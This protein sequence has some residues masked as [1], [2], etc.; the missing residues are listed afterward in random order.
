MKLPPDWQRLPP[1]FPE[2][3]TCPAGLT[4]VE[5][6]MRERAQPTK[7][8]FMVEPVYGEMKVTPWWH[9]PYAFGR[10]VEVK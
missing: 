5:Y 7:R 4:R 2:W 3:W 6:E 1:H 10:I 8:L 9:E